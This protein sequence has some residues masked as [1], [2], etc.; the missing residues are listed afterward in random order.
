MRIARIDAL[1]SQGTADHRED[2]FVVNPPFLGVIDGFSAPYHYKM[3]PLLFNGGSGGEMVRRVTLETF[4]SAVT[5]SVEDLILQ[6]NQRIAEAQM[7]HGISDKEADLLSGA[8]FVF[9]NLSD[10]SL[11]IIQG[12]DCLAVWGYRSGK[13]G[14]T[15]N[16]AYLHVSKNLEII[17]DLMKKHGGDAREMWVEFSPILSGRRRQDINNPK[18]EAGYAVLNG[19]ATIRDCWQKS[20]IPAKNIKYIL[21]FSDGFIPYHL[22]ENTKDMAE[23]VISLYESGGLDRMLRRK[24]K[25]DKKNSKSSYIAQDEATALA[26]TFG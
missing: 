25:V 23:Y 14:A 8:S 12:G 3:F 1:Y 15:K 24:R 11:E 22:T 7:S 19:Q 21:L 17:A 2:G 4:Y 26:I 16:Q 18:S 20:Q 13:F 10:S 9:A 5:S 6:A